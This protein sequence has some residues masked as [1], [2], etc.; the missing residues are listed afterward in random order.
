MCEKAID[1]AIFILS[2]LWD[3]KTEKNIA[4][5]Q[6]YPFQDLYTSLWNEPTE[7]PDAPILVGKTS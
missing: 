3:S 4:S 1:N 7:N 2:G 5:E 6:I